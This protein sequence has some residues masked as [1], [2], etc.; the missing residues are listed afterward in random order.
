MTDLKK[1]WDT[2]KQACDACKAANTETRMC[3][4]FRGGK[5]ATERAN[6]TS[7]QRFS[8]RAARASWQSAA[9]GRRDKFPAGTCNGHRNKVSASGK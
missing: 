9:P 7:Q 6:G 8:N 4:H 2:T 1:R 3:K 5:T